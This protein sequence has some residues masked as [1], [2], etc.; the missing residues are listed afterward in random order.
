MAYPEYDFNILPTIQ[1]AFISEQEA[2][3]KYLGKRAITGQEYATIDIFAEDDTKIKA[4]YDF[5]KDDCNYGTLAFLVGLPINGV[6][7]SKDFPTALCRFIDDIVAKK[8]DDHWTQ[9]IK[10]K[11]LEYSQILGI[12][13]DDATNV[14]V[15]DAGNI[16]VSTSIP[17]SNSNKEITHG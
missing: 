14:I 7:S 9:G 3:K 11:V 10:L 2:T 8:I 15:D 13:E 6:P 4:L 5:W 12:I 16:L 1:K 17:I